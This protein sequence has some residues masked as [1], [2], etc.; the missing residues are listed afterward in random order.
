MSTGGPP[1]YHGLHASGPSE[2]EKL[3]FAAG[4]CEICITGVNT[5]SQGSKVEARWVKSSSTACTPA[6]PAVGGSPPSLISPHTCRV[7]N[8]KPSPDVRA[9]HAW[10]P[11]AGA[12]HGLHMSLRW[13]T[14]GGTPALPRVLSQ[15]PPY[16]LHD[17]LEGLRGSAIGLRSKHCR[18][19][20]GAVLVEQRLVVSAAQQSRRTWP[21]Q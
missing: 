19:S 20:R 10:T 14:P 4:G 3:R 13:S 7:W 2:A 5:V 21:S 16:H 11:A 17:Q 9:V 1:V 6:G 8:L 15:G 12:R 18:R